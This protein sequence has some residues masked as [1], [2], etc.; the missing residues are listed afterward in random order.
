MF[1]GLR[2]ATLLKKRIW[3][4]CFPVNFAKFLR[5]LILKNSCKRL[6][7]VAGW[8]L[9]LLTYLVYINISV[10]CKFWR[11]SYHLRR[12]RVRNFIISVAIS[13]C[14]FCLR[15]FIY[16]CSGFD[17]VK[18]TKGKGFGKL[19]PVLKNNFKGRDWISRLHRQVWSSGIFRLKF[20]TMKKT[21]YNIRNSKSDLRLHNFR[22]V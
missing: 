16:I 4:R 20:C 22:E 18:F 6:L 11:Y 9:L 15:F 5:T 2:P 14:F 3:H 17:G 21:G 13:F 10:A 1:W 7:L 8:Y 12:S 19:W